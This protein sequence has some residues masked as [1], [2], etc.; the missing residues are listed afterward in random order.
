MLNPMPQRYITSDDVTDDVVMNKLR[1]VRDT[2][3]NRL[4][5]CLSENASDFR[6]AGKKQKLLI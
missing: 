2:K 1:F 4:S 6:E 3:F 5:I